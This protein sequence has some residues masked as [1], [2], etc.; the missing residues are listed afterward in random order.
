MRIT[1]TL[2]PDG[3]RAVE[4]SS[5]ELKEYLSVFRG[6]ASFADDPDAARGFITLI[7]QHYAGKAGGVC[8]AS[9][10]VFTDERARTPEIELARHFRGFEKNIHKVMDFAV[11]SR[12]K[13]WNLAVEALVKYD[14][15]P[16]KALRYSIR[17]MK[18]QEAEE[19]KRQEAEEAKR[20]AE[21]ERRAKSHNPKHD[22][23]HQF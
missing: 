19:A 23:W 7:I 4:C 5:D 14:M 9:A 22:H 13:Y 1:R 3:K 6:T 20:K 12:G 15:P 21:E 8:R 16:G 18:R 10:L 17:E 2:L 11:M